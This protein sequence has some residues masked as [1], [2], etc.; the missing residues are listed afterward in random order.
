MSPESGQP[1]TLI[2]D[3]RLQPEAEPKLSLE[4]RT[5]D[6]FDRGESDYWAGFGRL[7]H[8]REYTVH[9]RGYD[10]DRY[11][12]D[13]FD[14]P[15]QQVLGEDWEVLNR[16]SRLEVSYLGDEDGVGSGRPN[17]ALIEPLL[18][19]IFNHVPKD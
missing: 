3:N 4:A 17:D 14:D 18:E 1:F 10:S 16:G 11:M 13:G 7:G 19:R 2:E 15:I 5:R 12:P 8:E 6:A 9:V